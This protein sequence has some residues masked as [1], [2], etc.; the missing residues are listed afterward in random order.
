M[1]AAKSTVGLPPISQD[2]LFSM[3]TRFPMLHKRPLRL[4]Y[5]CC[6]CCC[7]SSASINAAVVAASGGSSGGGASLSLTCTATLNSLCA[8]PLNT[9]QFS[10]A[11]GLARH[12]HLPIVALLGHRTERVPRACVE[13]IRQRWRRNLD[14]G[15]CFDRKLKSKL[16]IAH[17]DG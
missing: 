4:D 6:C 10:R 7:S 11:R 12:Q 1:T 17:H 2:A 16:V 15:C 5:C 3:R 14:N 8:S 13:R 9:P